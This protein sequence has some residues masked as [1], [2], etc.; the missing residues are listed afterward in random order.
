MGEGHTQDR[1]Q[2][3]EPL[4]QPKGAWELVI[5]LVF[6]L[7]GKGGGRAERPFVDQF[8]FDVVTCCG[9][10]PQV[11]DTGP[12]LCVSDRSAAQEKNTLPLPYEVWFKVFAPFF[13][14]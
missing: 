14:C 6:L 9:Y 12:L 11:S 8:G 10:L 13:L 1:P 5:L 2:C 7:Q 3:P 4:E